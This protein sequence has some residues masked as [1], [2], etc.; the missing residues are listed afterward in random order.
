MKTVNVY[1][2]LTKED[3]Y[4]GQ[5]HKELI[6]TYDNSGNI[7]NKTEKL[8]DTTISAIVNPFLFIIFITII[9]IS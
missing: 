5:N 2:Y 1:G 9:N 8:N 6:Y 4:N 7:I 3:S